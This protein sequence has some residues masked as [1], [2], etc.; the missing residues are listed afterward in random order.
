M[1][2]LRKLSRSAEHTE[3][4][5]GKKLAGPLKGAITEIDFPPVEELDAEGPAHITRGVVLKVSESVKY[6][7]GTWDKIPYSVETSCSVTLNCGQTREQMLLCANIAAELAWQGA[8]TG[9]KSAVKE[10]EKSVVRLYP[11]YFPGVDPDD[12]NEV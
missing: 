2:Q 9:I 8:L 1:P 11:D 7:L 6:G 12:D 4:S 5:S 3:P 10:Q